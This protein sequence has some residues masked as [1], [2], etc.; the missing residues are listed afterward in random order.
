MAWR[1]LQVTAVAVY[2]V[3]AIAGV[4]YL[5]RSVVWT[6]LLIAPAVYYLL[7]LPEVPGYGEARHQRERMRLR[8]ERERRIE[9]RVAE[10]AGDPAN[11]PFLPLIR[12]GRLLNDAHIA[13]RRKRI[14]ELQAVP[15][16]AKYAQKVVEGADLTDAQIDYLEDPGMLRLCEHLRGV[17]AALKRDG[18]AVSLVQPL[19]AC[20]PVRLRRDGLALADCVEYVQVPGDRFG[21]DEA[22]LQCRAC[23]SRLEEAGHGPVWPAA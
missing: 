3:C 19:V 15:H 1:V 12:S 18:V 17:E 21:P 13:A 20:A 4:A 6:L 16:R 10:L 8:M 14:A 23:G 9:A 5:G 22:Y 11:A 2:I 7:R